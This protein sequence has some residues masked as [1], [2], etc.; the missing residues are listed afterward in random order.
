MSESF[1]IFFFLSALQKKQTKFMGVHMLGTVE[2]VCR[3][4]GKKSLSKM[5][6]LQFTFFVR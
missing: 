6:L 3:G 5:T 2:A 4:G 1:V